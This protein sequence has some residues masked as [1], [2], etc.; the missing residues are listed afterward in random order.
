MVEFDEQGIIETMVVGGGDVISIYVLF[1]NEV[2]DRIT[3]EHSLIFNRVQESLTQSGKSIEDLQF[4]VL[5]SIR[6]PMPVITVIMTGNQVEFRD[7]EGVR[8]IMKDAG[9]GHLKRFLVTCN[10]NETVEREERR[11]GSVA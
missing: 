6:G 9:R 8:E 10:L 5:E 4:S 7:L 2:M 1:D 11:H 3:R